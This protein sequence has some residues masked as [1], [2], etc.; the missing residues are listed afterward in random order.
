M[1]LNLKERATSSEVTPSKTD[2]TK[3]RAREEGYLLLKVHL[4]MLYVTVLLQTIKLFRYFPFYA[5]C[6]IVLL[7]DN[8]FAMRHS[9]CVYI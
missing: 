2:A 9:Y 7:S 5:K 6:W 4:L 1:N 8:E 3:Q